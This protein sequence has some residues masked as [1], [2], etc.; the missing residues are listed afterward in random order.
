M[1]KGKYQQWLTDDGLLLLRGWARAGAT[2]AEIAK[3]IGISAETFCV[4][5]NRFPQFSEALKKG[6]EVVDLMVEESGL[7]RRALGMTVTEVTTNTYI[8]KDGEEHTATKT[9]VKEIPPDVTA[10]IFW[11]KN[12][13]PDLWREKQEIVQ[14]TN[15]VDPTFMKALSAKTREVFENGSDTPADVED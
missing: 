6:K 1:A 11:L 7:L 13:R 12:R 3:K 10:Q 4:W 8:D 14:T 2:D 15:V 5:K 9:V